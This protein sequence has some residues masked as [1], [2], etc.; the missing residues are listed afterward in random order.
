[1]PYSPTPSYATAFFRFPFISNVIEPFLVLF[2]MNM[3]VV[4]V[5]VP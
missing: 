5:C 2:Y 3:L 1:M 4:T